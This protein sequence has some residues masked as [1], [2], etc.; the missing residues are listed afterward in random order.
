MTLNW[1]APTAGSAPTGYRIEAGSSAG[2]SNLAVLQ[3]GPAPAL[4]VTDVPDGIYFVRAHSLRDCPGERAVERGARGRGLR[5]S[6]AGA[7]RPRDRP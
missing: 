7:I 4:T 2:A 3:T 5:R 1:L 6:A